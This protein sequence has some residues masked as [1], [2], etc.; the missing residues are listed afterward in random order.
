MSE[1]IKHPSYA[2]LYIGRSQCS[3]QQALFGS[4]I[5]H[6]DIITLRISPA[7]MDRDLNYD[8]YYAENH[9]YI[10]INM[11]QS[12]FAQ[13]ITSLNMGAGVPVTLRQINGEYIEP[14]PF[15]DKREQFSNEFREDMNELTKKIKETT[16]AVEDLI[17]NKRTFTKADKEQ[18]LSTLHSV[19]QQ[20]SSNYPYMFSMFNEQMDKTVTEAKAEIESHLQA[21]MEDV[22]LKAM[23]K[24]QEQ[25]LLPEEDQDIEEDGGMLMGGM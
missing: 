6:H 12:Q 23:G 13:A 4:S 11:S 10:E 5:K 18:I 21:R 17:Q 20:L 8:R 9:P 24:S 15:V 2:N 7:Y 14:C 22:A 16:K 3:G 25:E 19:S 1:R